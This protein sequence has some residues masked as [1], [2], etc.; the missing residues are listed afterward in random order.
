MNNEDDVFELL[1]REILTEL[2][3][4]GDISDEKLEEIIAQKLNK[5]SRERYIPLERKV[6]LGKELLHSMRKLDIL[7]E[8][9]DDES[10]TEIMVNGYD[11]IFIEKAGYLFKTDREFISNQRYSDIIQQ[12]VASC[13]RA[14][15]D[16]SPIVD[17]RL[18]KE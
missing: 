15:N 14:V 3:F 2:E 13:N 6:S 18:I 1:R 8:L 9:I 11:T 7:Q 4:A 5:F 16:S 10:I 17:A 12:I